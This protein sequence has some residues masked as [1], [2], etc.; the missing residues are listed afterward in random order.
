MAKGGGNQIAM[1]INLDKCIGCHTCTVACKNLWTNKGG[2][3]Y[4]YWNNV[5]SRPGEGYPRSW[6]SKGGGFQGGQPD[7]GIY[8]T[9]SEYGLGPQGEIVDYDYQAGLGLDLQGNAGIVD[10]DPQPDMALQLGRGPG[11]RPVSQQLLF[12]PSTAVQSLRPAG[13]PRGLPA[14]RPSTSAK[15]TASSWSTRIAAAATAS[16]C[17]PARTKR[18]S[19]T[20][21]H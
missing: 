12:L 14:E 5:E 11:Q 1:V 21:R 20:H 16:A 19:S 13:V 4:M 15:R 8:P 3:E 10:A 7:P 17:G 2:R 6:E 9:N 18:S